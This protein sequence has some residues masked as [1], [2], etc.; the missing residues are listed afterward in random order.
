[1]GQKHL[2]L[3]HRFLA[4]LRHARERHAH[5]F[6]N[7]LHCEFFA[8]VERKDQLLPLAELG[9]GFCQVSLHLA[10]KTQVK[11]VRIVQVGCRLDHIQ[12]VGAVSGHC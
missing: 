1:M 8:V 10:L 4:N 11:R 6:R 12:R 7:F 5:N 3:L 2:Q 9:N